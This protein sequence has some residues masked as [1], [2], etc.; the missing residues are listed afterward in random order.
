MTGTLGNP[1][2]TG[3]V[4][5]FETDYSDKSVGDKSETARLSRTLPRNFETKDGSHQL[6]LSTNPFDLTKPKTPPSR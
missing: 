6:H 4:H 2:H 3:S 5:S 1:F